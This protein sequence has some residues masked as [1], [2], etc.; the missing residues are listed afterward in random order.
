[1]VDEAGERCRPVY[2]VNLHLDVDRCEMSVGVAA[3]QYGWVR[4]LSLTTLSSPVSQH[5]Q[6]RLKTMS[7]AD[8]FITQN[9]TELVMRDFQPSVSTSP[10]PLR[11]FTLPPLG[12]PP[13][14]SQP[15]LNTNIAVTP[16]QLLTP[17]LASLPL[18]FLLGSEILLHT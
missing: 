12:F 7:L 11:T 14:P 1:M 8:K 10:A 3:L 18:W 13:L 17:A 2:T 15:D 6:A 5:D 9:D 4:S 16:Q